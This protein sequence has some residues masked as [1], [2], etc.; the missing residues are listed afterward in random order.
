MSATT[1]ALLKMVMME[2]E[3][4]DAPHPAPVAEQEG[5]QRVY[6]AGASVGGCRSPYF[7]EK[8][9]GQWEDAWV[10]LFA[11]GWLGEVARPDDVVPPLG[12]ATVVTAERARL[13]AIRRASAAAMRRQEELWAD[14]GGGH[15]ALWCIC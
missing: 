7:G 5:S 13:Q 15:E 9:D 6:H 12:R 8:E 2:A 10:R 1:P 3:V 4:G 14:G 11:A